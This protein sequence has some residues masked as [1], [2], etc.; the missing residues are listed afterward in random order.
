V[1]GWVLVAYRSAAPSP[2]P[3]TAAP[4]AGARADTAAAHVTDIGDVEADVR[5]EATVADESLGAQVTAIEDRTV[6]ST[7]TMTTATVPPPP[8][9]QL[10]L[11][12]RVAPGKNVNYARR[13]VVVRGRILR[14]NVPLD[15]F[16]TVLGAY[17]HAQQTV[18]VG[19]VRPLDFKVDVLQGLAA[20][21]PTMLVHA[22]AELMLLPE[23]TDEATL[24]PAAVTAEAGNQTTVLSNPVRI[25]FAPA[26]GGS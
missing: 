24:D 20:P 5:I 8:P 26:G 2:A 11:R 23:G 12:F 25:N 3:K 22:Q 15:T 16:S 18:A 13:P 10:W 19:T 4:P 21:P 14:D 9:A 1:A 7:L 6:R 17:L